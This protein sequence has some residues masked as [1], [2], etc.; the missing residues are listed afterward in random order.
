MRRLLA[1]L[2]TTLLVLRAVVPAGFMLAPSQ[3]G[4]GQMTIVICT[5]H[6]PEQFVVNVDGT[7][8]PSKSKTG[9]KNL[10]PYAS[11]GA[12]VFNGEAQPSLMTEVQFAAVAYQI[13]RE[14]FRAAPIIGAHS[15]RGPPAIQ[16]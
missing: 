2:I 4:E 10:C 1:F 14:N 15:A 5:G 11:T 9:G 6:G 8:S 3:A 16:I 13:T 12:V 7:K